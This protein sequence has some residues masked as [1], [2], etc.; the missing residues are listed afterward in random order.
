SSWSS[1]VGADPARIAGSGARVWLARRD[2]VRVRGKGAD[3]WSP[4]AILDACRGCGC[5]ALR[6][7]MASGSHGLGGECSCRNQRS[8][9]ESYLGHHFLH[10]MREAKKS[11]TSPCEVRRASCQK[12]GY[13]LHAR[14]RAREQR[15]RDPIARCNARIEGHP[16]SPRMSCDT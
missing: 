16:A 6:S 15:E 3:V 4:H 5:G 11:S 12:K 14:S 7:D 13:I 8:R 10:L 1:R 2:S 9:Q